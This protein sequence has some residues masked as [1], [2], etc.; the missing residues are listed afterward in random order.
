MR[1]DSIDRLWSVINKWDSCL[2]EFD[3]DFSLRVEVF[4][5]PEFYSVDLVVFLFWDNLLVWFYFL[6][7]REFEELV[8][9][10][11]ELDIALIFFVRVCSESLFAIVVDEIIIDLSF[12][13]VV[14][15]NAEN[16]ALS[17]GEELVDVV[18]GIQIYIAW[19]I[20]SH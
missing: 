9:I 6:G 10:L 20:S 13:L 17:V 1:R 19:T 4:H 15:F 2:C 5:I 8:A 18:V 11:I 12:L 7:E 14:G 3:I 16:E